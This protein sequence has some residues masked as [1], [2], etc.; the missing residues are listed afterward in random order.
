MKSS[1]N[2][3]MS[4]ASSA[5]TWTEHTAIL[6]DYASTTVQ[7][8]PF[9]EELCRLLMKPCRTEASK[10][11]GTS[12]YVPPLQKVGGHVPPVPPVSCAPAYL[13]LDSKGLRYIVG[14]L[15]LYHIAYACT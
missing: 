7:Q 2:L 10:V 9:N 8:I 3:R 1:D 6:L 12:Y 11:G 13:P 5:S 14:Y 15:Y 4:V